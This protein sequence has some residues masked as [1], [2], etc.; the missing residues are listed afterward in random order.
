[1]GK[2]TVDRSWALAKGGRF[3]CCAPHQTKSSRSKN[4]ATRNEI[5]EVHRCKLVSGRNAWHLPGGKGALANTTIRR[6]LVTRADGTQTVEEVKE[7]ANF[8]A[9]DTR[10]MLT[11]LRAQVMA[12]ACAKPL[13]LTGVTNGLSQRASHACIQA[14]HILLS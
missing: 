3:V 7:G 4:A 1:M 6:V 10:A 5:F 14:E 12:S 8:D 2:D 9:M 11:S 13:Q